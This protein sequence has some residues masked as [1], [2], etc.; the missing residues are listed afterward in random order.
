MDDITTITYIKSLIPSYQLRLNLM[1]FV[2]I[3]HYLLYT[4]ITLNCNALLNL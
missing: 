2:V 1:G 4:L 3:G